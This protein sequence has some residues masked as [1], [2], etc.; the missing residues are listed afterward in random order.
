MAPQCGAVQYQSENAENIEMG[1]NP[2]IHHVRFTRRKARV[3]QATER[4]QK[5]LSN[6]AEYRDT[7]TAIAHVLDVLDKEREDAED[8][9]LIDD[10][11]PN[12]LATAEEYNVPYQKLRRRY[13]GLNPSRSTQLSATARLTAVQEVAVKA[14]C[15]CLYKMELAMRLKELSNCA[16]RVIRRST[17]EGVTPPK[18]VSIHWA[19]RYLQRHHKE[20]LKK[21]QKPIELARKEAHEPEHIRQWFI[22]LKQL[23]K[24]WNVKWI[25]V[26]NMDES[27]FRI[28]IGGIEYVIASAADGGKRLW[29]SC[30]T[31][32]T[33]IT[34][35]DAIGT[36]GWFS[37]P[38]LIL[39]GKDLQERWFTATDLSNEASLAV[40][41]SGYANDELCYEFIIRFEQQTRQRADGR[42]R[43]LLMDNYGSHAIKEI[44]EY[45]WKHDVI[46]YTL[47]P[48]TS[49]FLQPLDVAVFQQYKHYHKQ[50]VND[51]NY[52]GCLDYS[53]M[54]FLAA[55]TDIRKKAFQRHIVKAGWRKAGLHP[56]NPDVAIKTI[57][58]EFGGGVGGDINDDI[59]A[60]ERSHQELEP[61]TPPPLR[62]RRHVRTPT[63]VIEMERSAEY[64]RRVDSNLLSSPT[65]GN[66][67]ALAK[68][69]VSAFH[70]LAESID[71]LSKST[72]AAQ[73]RA[74][75]KKASRAPL[76]RGGVLKLSDGRAMVKKKQTD[77]EFLRQHQELKK[78]KK[79]WLDL[80]TQ[81]KKLHTVI[82]GRGKVKPLLRR[83]NHQLFTVED[84]AVLFWYLPTVHR[85]LD[86]EGKPAWNLFMELEY[87]PEGTYEDEDDLDS[88][89]LIEVIKKSWKTPLLPY[90]LPHYIGNVGKANRFG[91]HWL[92]REYYTPCSSDNYVAGQDM[93]ARFTGRTSIVDSQAKSSQSTTQTETQSASQSEPPSAQ[94]GQYTQDEQE[95]DEVMADE[96]DE[97][98]E[99]EDKAWDDDDASLPDISAFLRRQNIDPALQ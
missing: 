64:L 59:R 2:V 61:S 81:R 70:Q 4:Q 86:E 72:A 48:H 9:G 25:D 89:D 28:G 73:M 51:A 62:E 71:L 90:K 23:M 14:W 66:I 5:K 40:S 42:F 79:V 63:N 3:L 12:L 27:G 24:H 1:R 33:H 99:D 21:K 15:L 32:R 56:W 95:Q 19:T 47:P 16:N 65:I 58:R 55:V 84:S 11:K 43:L 78:Q 98:D 17:P 8:Q 49:H 92:N 34:S 22:D 82:R 67:K 7:E 31:N 46:P 96:Q 75:R 76:Q 45:L 91:N 94:I 13:Q 93:F 10:W 52:T 97:Q 41:E 83:T 87:P 69:G 29:A 35:V 57:E 53:N 68:A 6:A 60:L 44:L 39:K 88:V 77:E 85:M 30:E 18:D 20:L 54:E 36:D 50:A 37:E 38:F 74:H 26:Y 80:I